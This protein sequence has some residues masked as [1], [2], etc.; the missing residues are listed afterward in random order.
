M[1][2]NVLAE[3]AALGDGADDDEDGDWEFP[4]SAVYLPYL[5][6]LMSFVDGRSENPYPKDTI[7]TKERLLALQPRHIRTWMIFRAYGVINPGNDA[8]VTG[9]RSN[10]LLKAKQAISYYMPNKHVAWI[11]GVGGNRS[12]G[13]PTRHKSISE[14]I[15]KVKKKECRGQGV[16]A[17]DKRDYTKEEFNKILELFRAESDWDHQFKYPMMSLW[18]YH[19][20][21]RL[22]DTC[23]FEVDAPH[24]SVEFPFAILTKTKWSKNVETEL[25][26]PD[27]I[28]FGASDWKTCPLLWLSVY[29]DGWLK[30]HPN[31]RYMF[32]DNDDELTGPSNLNKRYGNRIKAVCWT[33]HD[34]KA[35]NNQTGPDE[36][37]IGTHSNRKWASTRARRK[38][39]RKEQVE[40]R[41]RWI[42]DLNSSIVSRH[43]INP[44]DYYTDALVASY[45]CEGGPI[46]Y[47]L[48]DDVQQRVTGIWLYQ[49]VVPNLL[50]RFARDSR[51][52]MVMVLAKLWA[53]FDDR[54]CEELPMQE[55]G[56]IRDAY[57]QAHGQIDGNPVTKV[58]L[59]ILNVDG[60]LQVVVATRN[61]NLEVEI[62]ENEEQQQE[63]L[64]QQGQQQGTGEAMALSE[65]HH[66]EVLQRLDMLQAEQQAMRQWMQQMFDRVVTNQRRYGGTVH[67]SFARA[68][69]QEQQRRD[70]QVQRAAADT[71]AEVNVNVQRP[72]RAEGP[73]VHGGPAARARPARQAGSREAKLVARPRCLYELWQEY[74]FGIGN[75]KPAKNFTSAERNNRDDGLKQKYH[76]RNKVW[77]LQ[78]YMCNAGWT[79]EGM[80]AEITR[81]Y[82]SS[83]VTTIIKGITWDSNKVPGNPMVESVGFRINRSFFAGVAR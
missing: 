29:L 77:K 22:D 30:R 74:Q 10:S 73:G 20:I 2:T 36:K 78:S 38:G 16:K 18:S 55:V 72:P 32:T 83:H 1:A 28:L 6:H 39:A 76:Y 7:F 66:Q 5:L 33:H 40:L 21:H 44:E 41:G 63:E 11:D 65:H 23:H 49:I 53:V 31:A 81:V 15:K 35:L 58:R 14:L 67:S 60:R 68:N 51:F 4:Q 27:Q 46:K 13:N 12:C 61:S 42:S 3:A 17:N 82:N 45:L 69:R 52:L 57:H 19:L 56:R 48:R 24:S 9:C 8:P 50:M 75:N 54:A 59:R 43:Y 47:I 64:Q 80:N 70:L 26:C 79:V 71:A 37:G 34:F 62:E 25:Q